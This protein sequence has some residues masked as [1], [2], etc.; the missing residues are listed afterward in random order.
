[1]AADLRGMMSEAEEENQDLSTA[2]ADLQQEQVD[3][4]NKLINEQE[5][6]E[7]YIAEHDRMQ[8]E[9]FKPL[10]SYEIKSNK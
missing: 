4:Q 2:N 5:D 8:S 3:L 10:K 9:S 7:Q 1:M 6:K